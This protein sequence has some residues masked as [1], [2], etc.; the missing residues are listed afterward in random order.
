MSDLN[1]ALVLLGGVTLALSLVSGLLK[2]RGYLPSESIIALLVGVAVGPLGLDLL[3]LSDWGSSMAVLEQ[4]ARLTVALAVMST[5]LRLPENYFR[6]RAASM[7]AL[8]GPGM[9]LMWVVSTAVTTW[10][11]DVPL[12][13]AA[14]V[15]AI[16]TPTDP[17]LAS[18]IV[19]GAT[20]ERSIPDRLRHL[21]SAEAGANDG[22]A[23]LLV[24]FALFMLGHTADEGLL[25]WGTQTLLW[26]A[27]GAVAL[28]FLLGGAV[29]RTERWLSARQSLEE[30][31][32]FTITIALTFAVLGVVKL[33]AADDVLAV[34][35][36]GVAYNWL[37]NPRDEAEEQKVEEVFNR[38]FTLPVFVLFGTA[39]PVS[40]WLALGWQG[41]LFVVGL[42]SLRR[43]PMILVLRPVVRPLDRPAAA[44]FVGWFGPIGVAALFYATLAARTTGS[45]LPWTL[46][47]L[48]VVGSI[49]AHGASATLLTH[50]YGRLGDDAEWW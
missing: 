16:V 9:V 22:G 48:A 28:G 35:V 4:I 40:E 15:G 3:R 42:L 6:R 29:G 50:R 37:S 47:S 14:L 5:A 31:S 36:A 19:V 17:V 38:V 20:A 21:L 24:F 23:Y 41:V 18:T 8:L 39:L 2:S 32:T 25:A 33:L 34:F 46:G 12:W 13:M 44:L 11:F 43:L 26:E 49:A 10:L 1:L 27:L 30:T 7:A 45:E